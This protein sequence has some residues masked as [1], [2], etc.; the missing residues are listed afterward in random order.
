MSVST[1]MAFLQMARED[2]ALRAV[3]AAR[4]E[5]GGY[6]DLCTLAAEYGLACT[7]DEIAQAFR[8]DWGARWAH[9]SAM[10]APLGP[11]R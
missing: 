8:I 2:P 7:A 1:A 4:C 5:D 10:Q 3:L 11:S 9:F 6:A